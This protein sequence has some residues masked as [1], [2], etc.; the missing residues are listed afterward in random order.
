MTLDL[1]I[2]STERHER[3]VRRVLCTRVVWGLKSD[4]GWCV[5]PSNE[6]EQQQVMPFWSDKAYALQ[7]AKDE[8]ATYRPTEITLDA[9]LSRWL[10]GMA[11]DHLLVGTNWNVNL[12]GRE[13]EPLALKEE[14]D[15]SANPH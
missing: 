6:D 12:C 5:S 8:W 1:E 13:M 7:C 10:P 4:V 2:A 14:M 15:K 3:F 9:F 11:K